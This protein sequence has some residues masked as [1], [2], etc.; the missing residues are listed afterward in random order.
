MFVLNIPTPKNLSSSGPLAC[1]FSKVPA[2]PFDY[3]PL[4]PPGL[5]VSVGLLR[6]SELGAHRVSHELLSLLSRKPG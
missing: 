6:T 4:W 1:L 5:S 2:A 3:R